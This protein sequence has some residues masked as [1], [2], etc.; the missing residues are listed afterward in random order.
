MQAKGRRSS[1]RM[2]FRSAGNPLRRARRGF[3][4]RGDMQNIFVVRTGA[5]AAMPSR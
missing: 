4:H 5:N 2:R 1:K 3:F